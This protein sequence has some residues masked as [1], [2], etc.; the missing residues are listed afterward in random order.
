MLPR[1]WA[2]KGECSMG[3]DVPT[4]DAGACDLPGHKPAGGPL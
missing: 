3:H 1:G 4:G 2:A